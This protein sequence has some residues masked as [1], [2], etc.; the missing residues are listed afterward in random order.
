MLREREFFEDEKNR[1]WV[2]ASEG[3][4]HGNGRLDSKRLKLRGLL[5]GGVLP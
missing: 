4:E 3:S 1:L 2:S 5:P